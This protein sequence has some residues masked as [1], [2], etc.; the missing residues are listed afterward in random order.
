LIQGK[1]EKDTEKDDPLP[2]RWTLP[3][4]IGTGILYFFV[5]IPNLSSVTGVLSGAYIK[6]QKQYQ[7][8]CFSSQFNR[9]KPNQQMIKL[10]VKWRF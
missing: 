5:K 7:E 9:K 4:R 10:A 1:V 3:G 2:P 8:L 6:K